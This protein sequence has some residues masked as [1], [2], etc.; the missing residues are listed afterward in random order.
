MSPMVS[1][2]VSPRSVRLFSPG[3][4]DPINHFYPKALNAT[5]HPMVS[6]F[7]N[8]DKDRIVNRYCHLHPLVKPQ[9]L[10]AILSYQCSHFLWAGADLLNVTSAS[11]RRQ[12]VIIENN[13]CPS[14]QK[15]MPLTDDH[16]EQGS[17]K[18]LIE[19]TFYPYILKNATIEGGLAVLYDKNL[20]EATG[21]AAVLADTCME[22]VYLV[23]F[24]DED[25]N[26]FARFQQGV[27]E[28]VDE[29][30]QWRQIRA[31]FRYVTQ[32]PWT[33]IPLQSKTLIFNPIIACLAGGRNKMTAAKAY[34]DFNK[35]WETFGLH[36]NTPQTLWDVK[37]D[38]IP[39]YIAAFGGQGVI[40][41]PYSNSGQG[42]FTIVSE[43]ELEEFMKLEFPY[44]RFVVQ[45]LIGNY[46]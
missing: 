23:P 46:N 37:K 16:Q 8:L 35:E 31:A 45:S 26:D 19:R 34:S 12:M 18:D 17:Y 22:K 32:R 20:M 21:Y 43:R 36:I 11:G 25:C 29:N 30:G 15:S 13:S 3:E 40:K 27:L 33:R 24:F 42:V 41:V 7:L 5:I 6:F 9:A 4:F 39:Q 38:E 14:G 2:S 44:D 10:K 28:I 1:Q